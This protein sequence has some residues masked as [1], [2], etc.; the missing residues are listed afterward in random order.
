[1]LTL[2]HPFH[3]LLLLAVVIAIPVLGFQI[4]LLVCG[5]FDDDPPESFFP[6]GTSV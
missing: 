6:G 3:I 5:P 4:I 2:I 1:M